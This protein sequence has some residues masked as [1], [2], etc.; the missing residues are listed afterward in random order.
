M[1]T[2]RRWATGRN[3]LMLLLLF[4]L[5]NLV[6]IPAFYP[7]FQ[8][9]D[10]LFSYTPAQAY[11]YI[12]SY[13]EAG[14]AFYLIAELTLDLIY[15]LI[16]GLLF[17]LTTLYAFQRGFPDH[18]WTEKLALLPFVPMLADYI[19]NA[20]VVLMLISFP[21][22]LPLVERICSIATTTKFDLTPLELVFVIGLAGWLVRSLRQRRHP[23]STAQ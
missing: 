22:E 2:L 16:L 3:I 18:P 5:M 21:R 14:R 19:E 15:P 12:S 4:L 13:G 8:A 9:L 17:S 11:Q 1:N 6:V 7:K 10:T 23:V 20:C